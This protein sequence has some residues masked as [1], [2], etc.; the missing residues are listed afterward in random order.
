M[1]KFPEA[2]RRFEKQVSLRNIESF[3]QL[4]SAMASWAGPK[5][6]YTRKQMEALAAEA[7]KRGSLFTVKEREGFAILLGFRNQ[8]GSMRLSL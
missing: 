7:R 2:F 3:R 1:D 5:W 6:M 4:T 8:H